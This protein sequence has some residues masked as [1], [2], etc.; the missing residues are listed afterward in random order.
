MSSERF[1]EVHKTKDGLFYFKLNDEK[2]KSLFI[3]EGYTSGEETRDKALLLYD[4]IKS[5]DYISNIELDEFR[6]PFILISLKKPKVKIKSLPIGSIDAASSV[7][8]R[9]RYSILNPSSGVV[10]KIVGGDD[11]HDDDR[12]S[13]VTDYVSKVST[14]SKRKGYTYYFRGHSDYKYKLVPGIYR[15]DKEWIK[16]EHKLYREIILKCPSE[17]KGNVTTFQNLVKMQHYSLP[18][19]L[20]DITSNALIALYF[21]CLSS[22]KEEKNKDGEV[23]VFRIKDSDVMYYDDVS[24]SLLSNLSKQ[25]YEFNLRKSEPMLSIGIQNVFEV[26]ANQRKILDAAQRDGCYIEPDIRQEHFNKVVC[27]KPEMDNPRVVRQDGAFLLF[28]MNV[29]KKI[30]PKMPSEYL[31]STNKERI[32]IKAN[33]KMKIIGEL[34]SLGIS[35]SSVYPEIEHVAGHYKNKFS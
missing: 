12:I 17:F 8:S 6:R 1:F 24:V 9:L 16:S 19:R 30:P 28:G 29:E 10:R 32:I 34:E 4:A 25:E 26:D 2:G 11:V 27:V 13:S 33:D 35:A 31:H 7:V 20:L 5:D 14:I 18:T 15:T 23:V 22:A 3:S 21:A